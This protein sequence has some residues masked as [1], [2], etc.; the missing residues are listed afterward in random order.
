MKKLTN[1]FFLLL[2]SAVA[3]AQSPTELWARANQAYTDGNY[4]EA[5]A[6]YSAIIESA[7]VITH[8]YAPVY[9]NLGNAHFKQGELSQAILAYERSLRLKP[10][11]KNAKYNL[12][13]AQT[14]IIDNIADTQ[15]FF[16]REWVTTLRNMLPLS[17]W[18][19]SSIILFSL[20]L[21]CL[22]LFAFSRS[23]GLRK[24]GFYISIVCLVCSTVAFA[25]AASLHHRDSVRAEAIITRGIVNAKASPDRS[26][27]ELF[28]LHEGTKVTIHEELG[29]YV[30]IEVGNYNGWIPTN[31]L[32][33]I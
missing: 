11:D 27:T 17:T 30:N 25:N 21:V 20:M 8:A 1:I 5:A 7:P 2:L 14:Q 23:L 10:T 31:T 6:D 16:L 29:G 9:Y 15:V 3:F 32:E 4:A 18:M 33:R 13:F 28:T 19:W 26:G 12:R 24:A 22:L